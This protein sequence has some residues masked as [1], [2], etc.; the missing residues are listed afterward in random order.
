MGRRRIE[1]NTGLN[2]FLEIKNQI[3]G[4]WDQYHRNHFYYMNCNNLKI[5][6]KYFFLQISEN[7]FRLFI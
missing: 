6:H 7:M 4:N 5:S 3:L 1:P 2:S